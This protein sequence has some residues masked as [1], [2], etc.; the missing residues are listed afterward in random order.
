MQ[1]NFTEVFL[2]CPLEVCEKRDTKGM[3]KLAREGKI[4]NFTG[5]S[6]PYEPPLNPEIILNT[7][8]LDIESCITSILDYLK[9]HQFLSK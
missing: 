9:S 3:Y 7:H 2:D 4:S 8:N 5:V 6:A 1:P